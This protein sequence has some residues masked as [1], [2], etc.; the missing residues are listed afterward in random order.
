MHVTMV[1]KRLSNG[2]PCR[3][4]S[5]VEDLLR[6]RGVWDRIDEVVWAVEGEANSPGMVLSAQ[7][8]V[9]TAPFFIVSDQGGERIYRSALQLIRDCFAVTGLAELAARY[10][11]QSAQEI[12]RWGIERFGTQCVIAFSGAEDV[13]LLDMAARMELP[14]SVFTLDTGRLHPETYAFIDRVRLHYQL[15]ISVLFPEPQPVEQ[16]VRKKGLFSFLEDGHQECCGIR[17]VAP[18]RRALRGYQAWVTGQRR[19]QNPDTRKD[20][21]VIHEDPNFQGAE[22]I[23]VKINPLARW[24]SDQVWEYIRGNH[25]PYNSL[26]ERGYIS[27]GC[28]P[29]T[30][31]VLPGQNERDGRWWWENAEHKECGL[32]RSQ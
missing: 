7:H 15:E 5:Q 4:C 21:E 30:R 11:H 19:D 26:H 13:V 8:G 18:L 1:K 10:E 23:L 2:E 27:I 32:H 28:A 16:L 3:K 25:V 29:C 14:V 12:L 9:E 20:I 6:Q 22:D 24:S 17:K 31:A